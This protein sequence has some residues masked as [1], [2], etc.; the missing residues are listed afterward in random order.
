MPQLCKLDFNVVSKP[1]QTTLPFTWGFPSFE[2]K[3]STC[4]N[5]LIIP[6]YPVLF[7]KPSA[8]RFSELAA[9]IS[10]GVLPARPCSGGSLSRRPGSSTTPSFMQT[11]LGLLGCSTKKKKNLHV[12]NMDKYG[13][14]WAKHGFKIDTV[15]KYHVYEDIFFPYIHIIIIITNVYMYTCMHLKLT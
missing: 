2:T 4:P 7:V 6:P 15:F 8:I 10:S 3:K 5:N 12:E 1:R 11:C 13:W 9:M 14:P